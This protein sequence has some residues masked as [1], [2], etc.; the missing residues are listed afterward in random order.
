MKKILLMSLVLMFTFLQGAF[1]QTRTVSGRVTDPKTG[2]G[3][4]GVTVLLK[5]TTNGVSTSADGSYSLSVPQ[6]GGT[7]SFSSVGLTSREQVIGSQ[8]QI[9]VSLATDATQLSEAIVVGY[10]SQNKTLV[11]GAVTSV[12]AKQFE[13]QPVAGIDQ[14]LQGRASGVQVTQ[15]SGT[16]GGGISVRIR[17]NNSISAGS[18]PLY[19]IDGVPI[20]TGQLLQH[21]HRQPAAQCAVRHQ[22]QRHCLD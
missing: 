9:N 14:V 22:P 1:A 4:P 2:D 19:V 21:W 3:L 20:N 18:D 5:G 17:G 12:D 7:L 11:T 15:N 16:P 10:G 6:S 13:G 8:S